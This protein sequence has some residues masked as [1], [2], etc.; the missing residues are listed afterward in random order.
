MSLSVKQV[1]DTEKIEKKEEDEYDLCAQG[2]GK[3]IRRLFT[4]HLY[5]VP[6]PLLVLLCTGRPPQGQEYVPY[7]CPAE[8]RDCGGDGRVSEE[9][10]DDGEDRPPVLYLRPV[11]DG[12]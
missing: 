2:G 6:A 4:E 12:A 9:H 7:G 10:E 5:R 11:S 3:R 8:G 1:W